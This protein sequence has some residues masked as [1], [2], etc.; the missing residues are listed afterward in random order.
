MNADELKE[1]TDAT[2]KAI[3]FE[4]H[5]Q[6]EFANWDL[7]WTLVGNALMESYRR[8]AAA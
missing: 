6:G 7:I 2:V 8:G 3:K 5:T 1:L 4:V